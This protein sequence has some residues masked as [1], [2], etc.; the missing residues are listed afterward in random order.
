MLAECG[1]IQDAT[2]YDMIYHLQNADWIVTDSYHGLCFSLIFRKN[3]IVLINQDRGRSRFDTL[4][5]LLNIKNHF[6]ETPEEIFKHS[7]LSEDIDFTEIE[8]RLIPEIENS[9][10]WLLMAIE[11]KKKIIS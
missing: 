2:I 11:S 9:K 8:Q 6:A 7:R 4:G 10:K 5:T 3:F 1:V